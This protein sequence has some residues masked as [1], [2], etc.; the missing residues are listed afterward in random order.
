MSVKLL[1]EHHLELLS[2]KEDCTGLSG[3]TRMKMPHCWKARVAP[4]MVTLKVVLTGIL[5]ETLPMN[6]KKAN[7]SNFYPPT[8]GYCREKSICKSQN[9]N[10]IAP[11]PKFTLGIIQI[12]TKACQLSACKSPVVKLRINN[13][14]PCYQDM[15]ITLYSLGYFKM[16]IS[17]SIFRQ[18]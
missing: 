9:I 13:Y 2:L 17:F 5:V 3:S 12:I 8:K 7:S 14:E 4:Q 18:H 6:T 10:P 11:T 16:M 1:T 15:P